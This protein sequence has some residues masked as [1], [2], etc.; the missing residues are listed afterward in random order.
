MRGPGLGLGLV[1]TVLIS[2]F[3]FQARLRDR[4]CWAKEEA[5]RSETQG[6]L[7]DTREGNW[8]IRG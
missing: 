3:V 2:V 4:R 6:D 5:E 7:G 1:R 8:G